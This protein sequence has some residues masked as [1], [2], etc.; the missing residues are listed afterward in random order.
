MFD[1]VGEIKS[2]LDK[3][4]QSA[5]MKRSLERRM[6]LSDPNFYLNKGLTYDSQITV[7]NKNI[8]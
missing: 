2:S 7:M 5:L 1:S 6:E 3:E 8:N 4:V